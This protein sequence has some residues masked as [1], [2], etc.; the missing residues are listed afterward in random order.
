MGTDLP[1][2]STSQRRLIWIPFLP[3]SFRCDRLTTANKSRLVAS[4]NSEHEVSIEEKE[5]PNSKAPIGTPSTGRPNR[6]PGRGFAGLPTLNFCGSA[7]FQRCYPSILWIDLQITN[8]RNACS[9]FNKIHKVLHRPIAHIPA[10]RL[11]NSISC[12]AEYRNSVSCRLLGL[13]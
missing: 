7:H 6:Q 9:P 4:R 3:L 11:L 2:H 8:Y 1:F 13:R 5:Q 10:H 12:E